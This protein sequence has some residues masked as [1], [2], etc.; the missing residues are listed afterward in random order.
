MP[1]EINQDKFVQVG[2]YKV[3]VVRDSCIGAASCIALSPKVFE[4]DGEK[5]A[6]ILNGASDTEENV[7]LA[8][9][10]CPTMAIIVIDAETGAQV[11]PN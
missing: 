8:A 7:L 2:R 10:S 6:V 9:Q 1:K 4:L 11:W 3:K 5:K